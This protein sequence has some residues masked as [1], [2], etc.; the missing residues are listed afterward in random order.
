M[1]QPLDQRLSAEDLR[2]SLGGFA[3]LAF[4]FAV[5][6]GFMAAVFPN[7]TWPLPAAIS[8]TVVAL[9]LGAVYHFTSRQAKQSE[10]AFEQRRLNEAPWA[11]GRETLERYWGRNLGQN[12]LTFFLSATTIVI[13]FVV[14]IFGIYTAYSGGKAEAANLAGAGGILSQ[15]I[16]ATLFILHRSTVTQASAYT[17]SLDRMNS[18]EMAWYILETMSVDSERDRDLKDQARLEMLRTIIAPPSPAVPSGVPKA[19]ERAGKQQ[20][21][22]SQSRSTAKQRGVDAL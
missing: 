13:G 5:F 12:T 2:I 1:S 22:K 16:G 21:I 15:F 19:S 14:L 7:A 17:Q 10:A 9:G 3:I 20:D 6:S 18:I 8:M 4:L 11:V